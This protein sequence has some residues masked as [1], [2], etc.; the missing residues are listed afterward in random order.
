MEDLSKNRNNF[1]LDDESTNKKIACN[2]ILVLDT[3]LFSD[4]QSRKWLGTST[5]SSVST[6]LK[7]ASYAKDLKFFMPRSI[8][9]ELV[10]LAGTE[11]PLID[12]QIT[13]KSPSIYELSIPSALF[14]EFLED[15]RARFDKGLRVTE[16]VIRKEQHRTEDEK[17][18]LLREKYRSAL[19]DGIVDSKEDFEVILLAKELNGTIVTADKGLQKYADKI[20]VGIIDAHV[21]PEFLLFEVEKYNKDI[22]GYLKAETIW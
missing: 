21:F 14:Y 9:D 12:T 15:L 19:R 10:N 6:F 8:R 5:A 18:H 2:R 13:I 20:G 11:I 4:P 17:I 7:L 16:D 22:I 3:S 1:S